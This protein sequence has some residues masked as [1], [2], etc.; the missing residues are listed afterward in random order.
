[1]C[2]RAAT[3]NSHT[4]TEVNTEWTHCALWVETRL[5]IRIESHASY[6]NRQMYLGKTFMNKCEINW[7]IHRSCKTLA[8][9]TKIRTHAN[10]LLRLNRKPVFQDKLLLSKRGLLAWR[11][12]MSTKNIHVILKAPPPLKTKRKK[13]PLCFKLR[14]K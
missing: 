1:M 11:I 8:Y 6:K 2:L 7:L 9:G 13:I 3:K 5:G 10:G 12:R 4:F 14:R